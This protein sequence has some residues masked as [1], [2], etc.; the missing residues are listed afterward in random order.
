[1]NQI[2]RTEAAKGVFINN[3][4]QPWKSGKTIPMIAPADGQPFAPSLPGM[5]RISTSPWPPRAQRWRP[6]HGVG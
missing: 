3:R 6:E 4:W 2:L 1:M 5:P